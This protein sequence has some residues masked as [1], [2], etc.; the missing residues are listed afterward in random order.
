MRRIRT[1][2]I[3]GRISHKSDILFYV[4]KIIKTNNGNFA[5]LKG[6][7]DR[8]EADSPIDDLVLIEKK[9][10]NKKIEELERKLEIILEKRLKHTRSKE[11][12]KFGTILHL[13]GDSCYR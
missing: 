8:I 5:I 3:V 9:A 10:I 11:K 13:D 12:V 1:G 6:L 7:M 4:K 2:D